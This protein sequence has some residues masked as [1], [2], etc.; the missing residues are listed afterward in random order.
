[1]VVGEMGAS[2]ENWEHSP[3]ANKSAH[4]PFKLSLS[5]LIHKCSSMLHL[6]T[7]ECVVNTRLISRHVLPDIDLAV[8]HMVSV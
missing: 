7:S 4:S 1:M 3:R 8:E 5:H 2:R 6:P